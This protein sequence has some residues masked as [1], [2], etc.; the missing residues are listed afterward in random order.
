MALQ[1]FDPVTSANL[2]RQANFPRSGEPNDANLVAYAERTV[3]SWLKRGQND[4]VTARALADF[5]YKAATKTYHCQPILRCLMIVLAALG[6]YTDAERAL[7]TYLELADKGRIMSMKGSSFVDVDDV[8]ATLRTATEGVFMLVRHV[9]DS[10]KAHRQADALKEW[11]GIAVAQFSASSASKEKEDDPDIVESISAGWTAYGSAYALAAR[12][13][14]N[15]KDRNEKAAIANA[16][17]ESARSYYSSCADTHYEHALLR[18]ELFRDLDGAQ[19][20]ARIAL[21]LDAEH[22]GAAHILALA[23]SARPDTLAEAKEVCQL[24][25][26][27]AKDEESLRRRMSLPEKR[28]ALQLRMTDIALTEAIDGVQAALEQVSDSL[29]ASYNDLFTW[30]EDTVESQIHEASTSAISVPRTPEKKRN[31][32]VPTAAPPTIQVTSRNSAYMNGNSSESDFEEDSEDDAPLPVSSDKLEKLPQELLSTAT[33]LPAEMLSEI[34]RTPPRPRSLMSKRS[35]M[36]PRSLRRRLSDVS[37]SS[38]KSARSIARVPITAAAII[39]KNKGGANRVLRNSLS[40]DDAELKTISMQCLRDIWLL[41]AGL[42]RR[43]G[44]WS[45]SAT[46]ITEA[47]Q[48]GGAKEDTFAEVRI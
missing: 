46:A 24:A 48:L 23:L 42:F 5:L 45:E 41:V 14:L 47:T 32:I 28:L 2:L 39:E 34:R 31:S 37:L 18:A 40:V 13:A 35:L 27:D 20:I 10:D 19:E 15:A 44:R 7:K 6:N 21:T 4:S 11:I 43:C 25:V 17:F 30:D 22:L 8:I 3:Q 26:R 9:R 16:A 38:R 1:S 29:F 33:S 12:H 36:I